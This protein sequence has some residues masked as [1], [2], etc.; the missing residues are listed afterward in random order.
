MKPT[1][2]TF[3]ADLPVCPDTTAAGRRLAASRGELRDFM[4]ERVGSRVLTEGL[5]QAAADHG[6]DVHDSPS[7]DESV[8]DWFLRV[9]RTTGRVYQ[10]RHE[11]T[12]RGL[13]ALLADLEANTGAA[14]E[15]RALVRRT[16]TRL[17]EDIDAE[18]ASVIR[19]TEI[20]GPEVQ[21]D[22]LAADRKHHSTAVVRLFMARKALK[23]RLMLACLC[24]TV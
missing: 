1:T 2:L 3:D 16:I 22:T 23:Q 6:N 15:L 5:L 9:L 18:Y 8:V 14:H 4:Q 20:E 10:R 12:T 13:T 7:D 17:T 21:G 24:S 19:R 11:V